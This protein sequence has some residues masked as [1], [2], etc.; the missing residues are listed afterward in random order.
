MKSGPSRLR[1]NDIRR[2]L[3]DELSRLHS[4]DP[5]TLIRHELG[6]C[7]GARRVDVAVVNGELA[8]YEIKSDE[9]TLARLAGQSEVYGRVLDRAIVVT[10]TRHVD[11][12]TEQLPV[13]WGVTVAETDHGQVVLHSV[14]A[15]QLNVA[16]DPFAVAQLL[17]R[18]EALQEL[19]ERG[20]GR[21]LSAKA[22]HY[23][24]LA[25]SE[26]VPLDDLKGIVRRRLKERPDWSGGQLP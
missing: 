18:E 2:R 26:A 19:R 6:L 21:G 1:D 20:L 13:W 7:A 24:W 22:R 5:E 15:P 9:D 8:G 14:R 17:W 11:Q 4:D 12:C 10:T 25:L 16:V 3:D 23:V